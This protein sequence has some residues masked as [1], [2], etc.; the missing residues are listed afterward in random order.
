MGSR[1]EACTAE[2]L[3]GQS[4]EICGR[5]LGMLDYG[6]NSVKL[7]LGAPCLLYAGSCMATGIAEVSEGTKVE[8]TKTPC[9]CLLCLCSL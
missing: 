8:S 3:C 5:V 1:G 9:H 2:P 6:A 4:T 7:A